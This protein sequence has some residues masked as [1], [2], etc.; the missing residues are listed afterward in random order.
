VTQEPLFRPGWVLAGIRDAESFF[1][2]LH[3]LVPPAACL[4]LEGTSIAPD[5]SQLL[6]STAIAPR[7]S[8][9][10]GTIL[11]SPT[12]Y[13]VP[14]SASLL[15]ALADLAAKHAGPELCDHLHLYDDRRGILQWYDAFELPMLVD[16]S[17][18]EDDIRRLCE[19]LR[20]TYRRWRPR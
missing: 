11:P 2:S 18:P 6:Q 10:A 8:I 15:T 13:H 3:R 14:A 5:V 12:T 20:A 16:D 7:R 4:V 17:I 19:V 1:R 9:P